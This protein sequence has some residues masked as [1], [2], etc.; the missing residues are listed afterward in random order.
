MI[1]VDKL[2]FDSTKNRN[3]I[4]M[5]VYRALKTEILN[6]RTAKNVKEYT[7]AVEIAIIR[8]MIK[9]RQDASEQYLKANRTDLAHTESE[10]SKVLKNLLP[11]TVDRQTILNELGCYAIS[12][13]FINGYNEIS[14]P[15][16]EMGNTIKYLKD[17][18]PTAEGK[19]ISNIVK[20]CV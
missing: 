17:K 2:I 16:K 6:Y 10:E 8:K 13:G 18:F 14:I 19:D 4:E 9:Q 7:E 15:K 11:P 12:K 3:Q 20:N 5:N 1:N